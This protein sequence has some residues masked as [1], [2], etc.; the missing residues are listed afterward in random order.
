[1]FY[2]NGILYEVLEVDDINLLVRCGPVQD[3]NAL[4]VV[5][6]ADLV[7]RQVESFGS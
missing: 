2:H 6:P 3:L 5:L 4:E 1:L 7:A